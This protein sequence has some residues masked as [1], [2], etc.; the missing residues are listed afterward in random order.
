MEIS[1]D[2]EDLFKALNGYKIKYLVVG[3]YAY[4]YHAE[5]RYTKDI[6][7]WIMPEMNDVGKVYKAL[8]SFG[9]PLKDISPGDFTNKKMIFQIGVPPVRIDIMVN[10]PGIPFD[11]A[12]RNRKNTLYGKTPINVL[13][14]DELI[15][16]KKKANR[17]QDKLDLEKLLKKV[18][19][20]RQRT[21]RRKK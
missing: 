8:K 6:D 12:W 10:V 11:I 15:K 9:A 17:P 1:Q 4:V 7:V 13:G 18:G 2:Y 3:A 21:K 16:S 5:P 19:R 14:I 20:R